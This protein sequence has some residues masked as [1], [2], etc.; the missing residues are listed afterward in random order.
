M[1]CQIELESKGY[2]IKNSILNLIK[3]LSCTLDATIVLKYT[4]PR[5]A[6]LL[7]VSK[8][9]LK[10]SFSASNTPRIVKNGLQLRKSW[11][12]KVKGVKNSKKQTIENYKGQFLNT[13]KVPFTLFCCY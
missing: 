12:P 3:Q 11:P 2:G 9:N 10:P 4:N 7:L 6:L 13:Q 1:L 5:R 8:Q